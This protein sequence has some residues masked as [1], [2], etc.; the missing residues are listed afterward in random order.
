[1]AI[2]F[3]III[4]FTTLLSCF[5]FALTFQSTIAIIAAV[6]LIVTLY[7]TLPAWL[8]VCSWLILIAT[9]TIF[10]VARLRFL[11]F[12]QPLFNYLK[13]SLPPISETEQVVLDAGDKWIETD[14]F[15]GTVNWQKILSDKAVALTTEEQSFLDNEVE[16][17]CKMVSEWEIY[18]QSF[19]PDKVW[20]YIKQQGFWA[21]VIPKEYGGK[22][23]SALAHSTIITKLAS[24]SI[25][26]AISVMIPN[27]VGPAE[28]IIHYGTEEQKQHYLPKLAKGEEIPCFALTSPKAGSD[29]SSI[30]DEGIVCQQSFQGKET[31][32]ILLSWD[33][34]YITLA[35]IATLLGL[36][37]KLK[38]PQH[39]LGEK[40]ELGITLAL[41]PTSLPG[42]DIGKR[43]RPMDLGFLNGPTSGE[44]VFIP[45]DYVIG[46]RSMVGNGWQMLMECLAMGRSL[47]LPALSAGISQQ[48]YRMTAAYTRIRKQFATPICQFEGVKKRLAR[49]GAYTYMLEAIRVSTIN[50]V[51]QGI[52]PSIVSAI[53]KYHSTEIARI[54]VNDAMDIHGGRGIQYGSNNYLGLVYQALPIL[55][56]VEGANL[57]TRNL[58]IFGQGALRCH[59]FIRDEIKTAHE[60]NKDGIIKFD[61][62]LS[63]HINYQLSNMAKCFAYGISSGLLVRTSYR[64]EL[65]QFY[66]QLTRMSTALAITADLTM[67]IMG[68]S[69]KRKE[70]I[71][72]RLGDVLSYL[73]LST[74][75]LK[76]FHQREQP[77]AELPYVRWCLQTCLYQIQNAFTGLFANFPS[78][79]L[80]KLLYRLV[81]PFGG[82]LDK[83]T[84]KQYFNISQSMVADL[85]LRDQITPYCFSSK[86]STDALG[87]IEIAFQQTLK[88]EAIEKKL[89]AHTDVKKKSRHIPFPEVLKF[90][91]AESLITAAER[92]QLES[93]YQAQLSAIAVDEFG[94]K[95]NKHIPSTLEKFYTN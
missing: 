43:H 22:E 31:L 81:F 63:R 94:K 92:T 68:G 3:Q 2:F 62:L 28:L 12:S 7:G 34:R 16:T 80:G 53:V 54:V 77:P 26:V 5:F 13:K 17:V 73:Y 82:H 27:S 76:Y 66:A 1:M 4:I 64:G 50:A 65:T 69:L 70:Q 83:P 89:F 11:F 51:S 59:P 60:N 75:V 95:P 14:L 33:K 47:S 91:E 37:F 67:A 72:A 44:D 25:S 86:D 74:A 6:M 38:D 36:A 18:E 9:F 39:L 19:L 8:L 58:I 88:T 32:G 20:D 61:A 71:S 78:K 57:L 45:I 21:L 85:Q 84:D 42:I 79:F 35:P 40:T 10:S 23:F 90:A 56:T 55:I 41:V 49:I 30:S 93:A 87:K 48:C 46:G 15:C 24:R 29:A 52:R